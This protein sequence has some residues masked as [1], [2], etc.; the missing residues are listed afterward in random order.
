MP[1]D[2]QGFQR[3][4]KVGSA[5]NREW[6]F[7]RVMRIKAQNPELSNTQISKRLGVSRHIID[8]IVNAAKKETVHG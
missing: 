6:L 5:Q 4:D 8:G 2:Y 1:R 7:Q 3:L